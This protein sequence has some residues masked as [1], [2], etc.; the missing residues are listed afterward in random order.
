MDWS[1]TAVDSSEV[2]R[3]SRRYRLNLLASAIVARRGLG[4]ARSVLYLLEEDARYLHNPFALPGMAVAVQRIIDAVAGGEPILV[5]GDRDVDGVTST[6]LMVDTLQEMGATVSWRLPEGDEPY[7]I[8]G[9]LVDD[10]EAAGVRLLITVDC[11]VTACTEIAA[12]RRRGI[13]VVVVDHH[14]PSEEVPDA[15]VVDPKLSGSA[16]PFV[17]L[18]A[19][20]VVWK[21]AWALRFARTGLFGETVCLLNARPL[22][23]SIVIEAVRLTN[24]VP[25]GKLFETVNPGAGLAAAERLARFADGC[26]ILVYDR[27]LVRSLIARACGPV[28]LEPH[29]LASEVT[30]MYPRTAGQSLLQL[31]ERS[32]LARYSDQSL[33]ELD[34]LTELF[35]VI[36]LRRYPELTEQG[37][38]TLDLVALSTI[39]DLM[40]LRDENRILV[41]RGLRVLAATERIGLRELLARVNLY[42]KQLSTIDVSF[43]LS[44]VVNSAGRMGEAPTAV[45]ILLTR[46]QEEASALAQRLLDLNRQRRGV[47]DQAWT[48]VQAGARRSYECTG[49]KLLW[50]IDPEVPRG[51]TGMLAAR[52][53]EAFRTPAI[54]VADR[55]EEASGSVRTLPGLPVADILGP[56]DDL[57]LRWGG[58]AMAGGFNLAS[59]ELASLAARLE[60]LAE[61]V[62]AVA[63][64]A[65][66]ARAVDAEIPPDFLTPEVWRTADQFAPYGAGHPPL[67][68][69]MRGVE[70]LQVDLVG[71]GQPAHAKLLLDAGGYRWPGLYWNAADKVGNEFAVGDRVNIVFRVTRSHFAQVETL[72]L[73]ILD[74]ER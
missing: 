20:G 1:K 52:L 34:V 56:V 59:A 45:R 23:D 7:G 63:A 51:I 71:K 6:A 18:S 32:K 65:A 74:L 66:A 44:P 19:C 11:G 68:F 70:I 31:R 47:A 43:H 3:I 21:L 27:D 33:T 62:D 17:D 73:T 16:Y 50:V 28:D 36:A 35:T 46:D 48:R 9:A 4:D 26:E 14:E 64:P 61:T 40:P 58:H 67:A 49:G 39:A 38:T 72:Q 15:L 24:L 55:G 69:L 41:K 54:V 57:L 5:F 2:R 8:T 42:G 10:L 12:A 22:Q 13:D 29:D 53:M 25:A 60:K 37:N 30:E